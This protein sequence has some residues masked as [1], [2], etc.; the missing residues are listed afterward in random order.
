MYVRITTV[1]GASDVEQGVAFIR[2]EVE[3]ELTQ[4][5]GFRGIS[6]SGDRSAGLAVVL[7]LW[8]T[9]ADLDASESAADKARA[10]ALRVLGGSQSVERY[11]QLLWETIGEGPHPGAQLVI[12]GLQVDA[13]RIDEHLEFFREVVLPEI[14]SAPGAL[15]VRLLADRDTGQC[16]VGTVW[17]DQEARDGFMAGT[18]ERQARA[19][20][21]GVRFTGDTS[22][23]ILYAAMR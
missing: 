6:V 14:K 19:E 8:D 21:R 20:S 5:A 17:T 23:E 7:S 10:G 13:G 22:L 2:E 9:R 18:A 16:R 1:T 11:E 15:G 3:P 4:Q 12:R